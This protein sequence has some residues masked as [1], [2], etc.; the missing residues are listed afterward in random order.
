MNSKF[1]KAFSTF[2]VVVVCIGTCGTPNINLFYTKETKRESSGI[3]WAV[4]GHGRV[5][6]D[7][8]GVLLTLIS[9]AVSQH[10]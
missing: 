10:V 3:C 7:T 2:F 5:T 8:Q 1:L 6:S 4:R 9:L